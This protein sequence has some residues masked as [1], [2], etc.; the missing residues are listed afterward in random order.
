M[1][2]LKVP[3]YN[4]FAVKL[5]VLPIMRSDPICRKNM[6]KFISFTFDVFI[7]THKKKFVIYFWNLGSPHRPC[8]A[9]IYLPLTAIGI[10]DL[11]HF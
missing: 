11:L 1:T 4:F 6:G 3:F 7:N 2:V 8:I 5:D 10:R 9:S